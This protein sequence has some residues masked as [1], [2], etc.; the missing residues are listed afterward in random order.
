MLIVMRNDAT[1]QQVEQVCQHIRNLGFTPNKIPGSTR[2]AIGITGNQTA[3]DPEVFALHEGIA[4]CVRVSRPYKLVSREVK[5][6]DTIVK[7][8]DHKIGGDVLTVI[9]GP[10]SVESHEQ[11]LATAKAVKKAGAQ[12]LRGGAFKPRTNPYSFQGMAE[13]G[14]KILAQ[15][16][17]ETGLPIVTEVKDTETLPLVAEYADVLQIGARNMQNFSLL[18]AA[19]KVGKPILLKKGMSATVEELLQAAEYIVSQG[20]FDVILCERGIRTFETATRSTLDI[21]AAAV[22]KR[23]SHLPVVVDPSHA[24]GVN[25]AVAPLAQAAVAAGADGVI[26]EVHP[27]PKSALC[28]GPQALT[29]DD[30][31]NLMS[32]LRPLAE[33]LGKKNSPLP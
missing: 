14:L 31:S 29:F 12:L 1:A 13:E 19:G 17:D 6:E 4:Q 5:H 2:V 33:L 32:K 21:S 30:F 23:L 10:C 27:D 28:D 8:G 25:W 15:A 16:R 3:I 24:A 7:V 11:V 26:I 18:Q 22:I 9:A 20:N